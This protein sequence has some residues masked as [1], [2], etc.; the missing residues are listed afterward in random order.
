M[1]RL[2]L[3]LTGVALIALLF[4]AIT[5]VH[6]ASSF[7]LQLTTDHF[8][9]AFQDAEITDQSNPSSPTITLKNGL[10]L[11]YDFSVNASSGVTLNP[12]GTL[13]DDPVSYI[14]AK[15]H[16]L[17]PIDD[18]PFGIDLSSP[19]KIN[20]QYATL[21]LKPHFTDAGQSLSLTLNPYK[22]LPVTLDILSLLTGLLGDD[23]PGNVLGVLHLDVLK[24]INDQISSFPDFAAATNDFVQIFKD[25]STNL[26]SLPNDMLIFARQILALASDVHDQTELAQLLSLYI[27]FV[28]P[29][30][31]VARLQNFAKGWNGILTVSGLA[32]TIQGELQ[33]FGAYLAQQGEYPTITVATIANTPPPQSSQQAF[34]LSTNKGMVYAVNGATGQEKWHFD[35]S[36][37]TAPELYGVHSNTLVVLKADPVINNPPYPGTLYGLDVNTGQAKWSIPEV[38]VY[39]SNPS[40]IFILGN[41]GL[42][43]I[44]P[45]SGQQ[46]WSAT[47]PGAPWVGLASGDNVYIMNTVDISRPLTLSAYSATTGTHLWDSSLSSPEDSHANSGW[48]YADPN[49]PQIVYATSNAQE[50]N[51][52][53]YL[54]AFYARTGSRLWTYTSNSGYPTFDSS[55]KTVILETSQD[56]NAPP[57]PIVALDAQSGGQEWTF[58]N[59]SNAS[60]L[61]C[62]FGSFTQGTRTYTPCFDGSGNGVLFAINLADGSVSWKQS[63]A[64]SAGTERGPSGVQAIINGVVY[65]EACAY[66]ESTPSANLVCRM[67]ALNSDDGSTRWSYNGGYLASANSAIIALNG[68]SSITALNP[69]TGHPLWPTS[70]NGDGSGIVDVTGGN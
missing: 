22:A 5:P 15:Y 24:K 27:G 38:A 35:A 40:Y 52:D 61:L 17:Q 12:V 48:I 59:G 65:Y 70:F 25:A 41:S 69:N 18:L 33:S 28:P 46:R 45:Q 19:T 11:W 10:H 13:A 58:P 62:A 23:Q 31:I 56:P 37:G 21:A 43:A 1:R 67:S 66:D 9:F 14:M 47:I 64:I 50:S 34:Y 57:Q 68:D 42:E 39:A 20:F 29:D 55:D 63:V 32:L 54:D 51:P 26:S 16:L 36:G 44:D 49:D 53:D 8:T 7:H 6:A 30:E 3:S 4:A 2:S 60:S